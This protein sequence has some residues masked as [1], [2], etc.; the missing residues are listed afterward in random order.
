MSNEH[1]QAG[2]R[3]SMTTTPAQTLYAERLNRIMDAVALRPTDRVP[4]IFYT[5]FWHA[6][7]GGFSCRDAMYDYAKVSEVTRRILLEFQPDAYLLPHVITSVGPVM[8]RIGFKQMQWP[9]YGTGDNVSYQY[10]DREYM[11]AEE[12]EDYIFDPTG[13]YLSKYLPRV[14]SEFE[15]LNRLADLPGMYYLGMIL[16]MRN[17]AVPAVVSAFTA[18]REA[19]EEARRM[20]VHAAALTKELAELGFPLSQGAMANAPFDYFGD[21]FRGSKGIMLDMY[22]RKDQL[23]AA[24][25]KAG[26][27]IL[28]QALAAGSRSPSKFVFIPT[29]W[30]FDGFMSLP[31]FKTFYWPSFRTLL[32]G[33]I[34]N[35]LIPLVLWEGDCTSR[36]EVIADLPPGKAVYWFER[37]DLA[38]AKEVLGRIVCLRGN[39]TSSLM[40]TGT[41]EEVDGFC[42]KLIE[43][44]GK[45]GGFI[46]DGAIGI[47]DEARTENV[48]AMFAAAR[49]YAG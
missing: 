25:D 44:V 23:L 5:M 42:R 30:A 36:L 18:M 9:G 7:Y 14:A 47:P 6:R 1:T 13:F 39:V 34:D 35:G 22:R 10:L 41:P 20:L 27:F 46:L 17:Y 28:R 37:T 32:V 48:K 31:Q 38:R 2:R 8:E 16:G 26:V 19:G 15:G 45:D 40:T 4:T 24:M 21:S 49:K 12:Y 3:R 43:T 29:H 33:L 11:K